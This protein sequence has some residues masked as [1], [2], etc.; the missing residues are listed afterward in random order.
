MLMTSSF[1]SDAFIERVENR[2]FFRSDALSDEDQFSAIC[3]ERLQL[4]AAGDEIEKLRAIGQANEAFC[5]NHARW[6]AVCEACK[7]I[8][9][10]SFVRTERERFEIELMPVLRARDFFLASYAEQ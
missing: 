7:A 2:L 5:P 10:K 4:P 3:L 1:F 8:A 9:R 6:Q